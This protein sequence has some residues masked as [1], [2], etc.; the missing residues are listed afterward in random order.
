M[1]RFFDAKKFNE[2]W[3][4][5][6]ISKVVQYYGMKI[7]YPVHATGFDTLSDYENKEVETI[8]EYIPC[9]VLYLKNSD[10]SRF[11]DLK[12]RVKND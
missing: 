10:K 3:N 9:V 5:S 11:F 1:V 7:M 12:M 4:G 6:L 8:A 2:A